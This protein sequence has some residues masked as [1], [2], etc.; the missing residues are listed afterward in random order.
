M[1]GWENTLAE[2]FDCDEEVFAIE[3]NEEEPLWS[4]IETLMIEN[5]KDDGTEDS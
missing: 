5:G 2:G 1:R 4:E 3:N